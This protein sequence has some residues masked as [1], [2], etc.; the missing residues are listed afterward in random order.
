MS[1][2]TLVAW[3]FGQQKCTTSCVTRKKSFTSLGRNQSY[4]GLL[5]KNAANS[6]KDAANAG[7]AWS[8]EFSDWERP[9]PDPDSGC[10]RGSLSGKEASWCVSKGCRS[11]SAQQVSGTASASAAGSASLASSAQSAEMA[12]SAHN[13]NVE[14]SSAS[15]QTQQTQEQHQ[16]LACISTSSPSV[17]SNRPTASQSQTKWNPN[18]VHL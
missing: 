8:E 5:G 18:S 2:C 9:F 17:T 4:Q 11:S 6:G 7:A 1:G 10:G 15:Q 12:E 3:L 14:N 13:T 16:V